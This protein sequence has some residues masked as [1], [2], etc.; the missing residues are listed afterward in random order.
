MEGF[1]STIFAY[2]MTGSGKTHTMVS[3][4]WPPCSAFLLVGCWVLGI[5]YGVYVIGGE[6][7]SGLLIA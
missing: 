7:S 2:G 1:N 6:K 4:P 3:F 5:G